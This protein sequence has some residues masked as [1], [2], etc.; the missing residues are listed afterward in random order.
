MI[1]Q[2][3]TAQSP[4]EA[5][6]LVNAGVDQVGLTP[7]H[8][9]LLGEISLAAMREIVAAVGERARWLPAFVRPILFCL[10][11]AWQS[12]H[13]FMPSVYVDSFI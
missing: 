1:I 10:L 11:V 3:Y 2:I 4:E 5:L 13:V 7:P 6:A 9:G 8:G 12:G